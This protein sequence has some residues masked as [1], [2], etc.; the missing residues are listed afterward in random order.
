MSSTVKPET[1][2]LNAAV[3]GIGESILTWVLVAVMLTL[4][5]VGPQN[6]RPSWSRSPPGTSRSPLGMHPLNWLPLRYSIF[7]LERLPN[8]AGI[9]PVN[10][11]VVRSSTGRL[12]R[13]PSP[14][15]SCRSDL[16]QPEI[17]R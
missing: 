6:G 10:W 4:I 13:S 15:A 12:E 2:S 8:S 17:Y 9:V 16:L 7:R 5:V 11:F 14:G 3:T 1:G